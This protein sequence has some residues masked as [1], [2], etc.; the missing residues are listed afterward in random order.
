MRHV[1]RGGV[2]LR[3]CDATWKDC[4]NTEPSKRFG[5]RWNAPRSFGVLYLCRDKTVA[6]ANARWIYERDGRFTLF[7]R[8]PG[9][10]PYLQQ[11]AVQPSRFVD[12]ATQA[13]M[14]SLALPKRYP[15]TGSYAAC[16]RV[17]SRAYAAGESGIA[18]LSAA[19][20]TLSGVVGEE[21]ALFDSAIRLAI[22]GTRYPFRMW[23]PLPNLGSRR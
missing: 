15:V 13:G 19:E 5:G 22:P 16:R 7:D 14:A 17:G 11:F 3:V 21:L 4:G 23:Y 12:A 18:C 1:T 10:R 2:H 8:A 20:A 9:R 6:A